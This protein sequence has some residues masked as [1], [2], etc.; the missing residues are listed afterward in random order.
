MMN[1]EVPLELVVDLK[2]PPSAFRTPTGVSAHDPSMLSTRCLWRCSGSDFM[3]LS[4]SALKTS[5]VVSGFPR[6]FIL[7]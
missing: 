4:K 7:M 5:K 3:M 1:V 2:S 6:E